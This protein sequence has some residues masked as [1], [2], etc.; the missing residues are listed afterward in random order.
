[1]RGQEK[2]RGVCRVACLK[3][4]GR[5]GEKHSLTSRSVSTRMLLEPRE[6]VA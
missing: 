4:L 1:M 5:L 6:G 2:L 3:S